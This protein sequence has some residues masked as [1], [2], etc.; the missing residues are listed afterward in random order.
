MCG[1]CYAGEALEDGGSRGVEV[2]VGYAEDAAVADGTE[3]VPVALGDEALEGDAIPC[4][5]PGEE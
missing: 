1:S 4:P 3:V 2:F 5:A